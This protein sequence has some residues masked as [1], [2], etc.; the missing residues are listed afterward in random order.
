MTG[1]AGARGET[2]RASR[3]PNLPMPQKIAATSPRVR[4]L[5]ERLERS[6]APRIFMELAKEHQAAGD[7]EEAARVCRQGLERHPS[8]HSARVLLARVLI[9][10]ERFG[11]AV[12]ELES[13][14]RQAPDNL[15]ARRLLG[16]ARVGSGDREGGLKTLRELQILNPDDSDLASRIRSLESPEEVPTPAAQ[17]IVTP[18]AGAPEEI[19]AETAEAEIAEPPAVE[20]REAV[21]PT[22][23]PEPPAEE[24]AEKVEEPV[25][26]EAVERFEEEV[27][28]PSEVVEARSDGEPEEVAAESAP[29]FKT[30][31][32][33]PESLAAESL[34]EQEAPRAEVRAEAGAPA[35]EPQQRA[36]EKVGAL[37]TPTLA[38]IYY[39]QGLPEKAAETYEQV[40]AGDPDNEEVR[41]RL[42]QI[43]SELP[44]AASMARRKIRALETWLGRIR[45]SR[46]AQDR[47]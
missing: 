14:V 3:Q 36:G 24:P 29:E 39:Q 2:H 30:V 26:A 17:E 5:T 22:V 23:A 33:S 44:R 38:E 43:R 11:D 16:E 35:E 18:A 9:D 13:V 6:P 41:S 7:L 21:P 46:N 10:L 25:S 27:T 40:L 4:E 47:A 31:A 28:E 12:P 19:A 8:Y 42:Q 37:A 34:S 15:L 32:L 1:A 20:E 45:R